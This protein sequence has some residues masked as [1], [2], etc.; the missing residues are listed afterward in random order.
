M[1]TA[2]GSGVVASIVQYSATAADGFTAWK[3]VLFE[4]LIGAQV[5]KNLS[6]FFELRESF[7]FS[8]ETGI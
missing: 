2:V 4:R 8:Q 7:P 1:A 3:R 5:V 6:V